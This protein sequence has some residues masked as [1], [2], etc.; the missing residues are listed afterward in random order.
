MHWVPFASYGYA[1]ISL[2]SPYLIDFWEFLEMMVCF[3]GISILKQFIDISISKV[4]KTRL[5]V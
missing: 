2:R 3:H 5:V 1:L 4:Q